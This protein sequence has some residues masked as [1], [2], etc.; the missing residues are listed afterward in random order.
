MNANGPLIETL[1]N[2][3]VYQNYERAYTETT[4]QSVGRVLD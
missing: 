3:Q 1:S 4:G 2:S